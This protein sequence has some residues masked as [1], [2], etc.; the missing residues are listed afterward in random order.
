MKRL[1]KEE[2]QKMVSDAV[3]TFPR[4]YRCYEITEALKKN[5]F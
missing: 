5:S 4:D 2:I 1:P 3:K